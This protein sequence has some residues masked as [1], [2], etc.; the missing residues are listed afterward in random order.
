MSWFSSKD[1]S[2]RKLD[3]LISRL[4]KLGGR[5]GHYEE[6]EQLSA[7][8]GMPGNGQV[9][10]TRDAHSDIYAT[11]TAARAGIASGEIDEGEIYPQLPSVTKAVGHMEWILNEADKD[12][13]RA[14][15][16]FQERFGGN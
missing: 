2:R 14:K 10:Q 5:I 16:A 9:A 7:R 3:Q 1:R 6:Q 8:L 13:A 4:E 15:R 11:L 12:V